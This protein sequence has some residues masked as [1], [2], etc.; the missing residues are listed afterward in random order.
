M[1]R[2]PILFKSHNMTD[3]FS[4][5]DEEL[6]QIDS[7]E[8][9]EEFNQLRST[10]SSMLGYKIQGIED[11]RSME[12]YHDL[13][14]RCYNV[15]YRCIR[16]GRL[17]SG[18]NDQYS[19]TFRKSRTSVVLG[20]LLSDLQNQED[21]LSEQT[22]N[23]FTSS[24]DERSTQVIH[25]L[26]R[27]TKLNDTFNYLWTSDMLSST[28]IESLTSFFSS[29]SI[30]TYDKTVLI[31]SLVL[32]L[33]EMYDERKFLFLTSCYQNF[34]GASEI[35]MRCLVGIVLL[36]RKYDKV[37]KY[38]PSSS[39]SLSLLLDD[40]KFVER[41]FL[42][43]M[44]LQFTRLT[45]SVSDRMLND[46]L[47]TLMKHGKFSKGPIAIEDIDN[48][49]TQNGENPEWHKGSVDSIAHEK[50]EEMASLQMEG[51][52]VH[53]AS[54]RHTKNGPF[55]QTMS[56]WFV[57]FS[58][59]H[60]IVYN[61]LSKSSPTS[62]SIQFMK[63]FLPLAP[64]C[65][66]DKYSFFFLTLTQL[67][68]GDSQL[69]DMMS[70][71]LS[72][73]MDAELEDMSDGYGNRPLRESTVSRQYVEELYR[74]FKVYPYHSEF[75]DPFSTP[76]TPFTPLSTTLFSPLKDNNEEML[77]L[78]EF[79]MRKG[80]YEDAISLFK[81]LSPRE[82]ESDSSI[83]QKLGFCEQKLGNYSSAMDHYRLAFNLDT[84]SLWTLKHLARVS[85]TEHEYTESETYYDMLLSADPDNKDYLRKKSIC[86]INTGNYKSALPILYKLYYLDE[87]D[88]DVIGDIAKC[89]LLTGDTSKSRNFY[90]SLAEKSPKDP[91]SYMNLGT[92][93]YIDGDKPNAYKS[94]CVAYQ[95]LSSDSQGRLKF[96]RLFVDSARLVKSV[97][98]EVLP[99]EMMYD[100]V[101]LI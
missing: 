93:S 101:L 17:S 26:N 35:Q 8:L 66:S 11:P 67:F 92:L 37:F 72:E 15:Y 56:N 18:I 24:D 28:D 25:L 38:F 23:P 81:S 36:I 48:Y 43:L 13:I 99:F 51:A 5:L 6:K 27:Q 12:I 55:F 44:Q 95:L 84:S 47:P 29:P 78:G 75:D 96:K 97:G 65:S 63:K 39:S 79:F 10:Y 19:L 21:I 31:S 61:Q 59:S 52:D 16:L 73:D 68:S 98:M 76:S 32:S 71:A 9:R 58:F 62:S 2:K 1:D 34:E 83:W 22:I 69:G 40:S 50:M 54:F 30:P 53:F 74:F 77:S 20:I 91:L 14:R 64:F 70:H 4:R 90:Q 80:F 49:L 46:I 60:P 41:V 45:D 94:F 87:S 42:A 100:A 57:P 85:F 33:F 7:Y 89:H 88:T 3:I 82:R 86:Q